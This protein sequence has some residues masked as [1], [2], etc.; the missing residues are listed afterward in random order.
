MYVYNYI[1]INNICLKLT[2][3]HVISVNVIVVCSTEEID[4]V[5]GGNKKY[6]KKLDFVERTRA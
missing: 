5:N 2:Y 3:F 4:F 6:K 1:C